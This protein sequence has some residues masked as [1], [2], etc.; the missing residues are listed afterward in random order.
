M[1]SD[2]IRRE[3]PQTEFISTSGAECSARV[4]GLAG[5]AAQP[6]RSWYIQGVVAASIEVRRRTKASCIC[7]PHNLAKI[8]VEGSNPFAPSNKI[9]ALNGSAP[10]GPIRKL[11]RSYRHCCERASGCGPARVQAGSSDKAAVLKTVMAATF[12]PR[13]PGPGHNDNQI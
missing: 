7:E 3:L 1:L 9:N 8:G 12:S 4:R 2:P 11:P 13:P 5:N 10:L 6:L